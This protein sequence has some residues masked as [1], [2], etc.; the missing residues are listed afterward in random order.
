MG[1][2]EGPWSHRARL[3]PRRVSPEPAM[4]PPAPSHHSAHSYHHPAQAAAIS[5]S[6]KP[7]WT[8]HLSYAPLTDHNTCYEFHDL[9]SPRLP[10]PVDKKWEPP[11]GQ[12]LFLLLLQPSASITRPGS[13][14]VQNQCAHLSTPTHQEGWAW[15]KFLSRSFPFSHKRTSQHTNCMCFKVH[16]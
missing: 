8:L 6:R 4:P 15:D 16:V 2:F 9:P 14:K 10:L 12:G 5:S 11:G 1:W 13:E 3:S 7:S